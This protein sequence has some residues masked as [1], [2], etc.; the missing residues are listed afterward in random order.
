MRKALGLVFVAI[1]A[2][3]VSAQNP[4]GAIKGRVTD[5]SGAGVANAMVMATNQDTNAQVQ[6]TTDA[7]GRFS[8]ATL[9]P[10]AYTVDAAA[11]GLDGEADNVPVND[12]EVTSLKIEM[13]AAEGDDA[14]Q[15]NPAAGQAPPPEQAPATSDAAN[16]SAPPGMIDLGIAPL[17]PDEMNAVMTWIAAQVSAIELPYCYR[18][19]YGNG[20]GEPYTCNAGYERNGLLCYPKCK[21]GF[22]GNGPVCWQACPADF[23]DDGAYCGKPGSYGRGAGYVIWQGDQCNKDNPQGCEQ[24][25]AMWYPKCK[26]NFHAAGCCVCSPDCPPGMNDIGVSCQKPSYGRGA[27]EPLVAGLC[28][29][30]LQKD[31]AGALCYPTCKDD[32]HMVGPVCWQNCPSQQPFECG[33][34]CSTN[35]EK[36]AVGT[37]NMVL[38]P[39]ELA[40][41]LIPY[42]GEIAGAAHGVTEGVETGLK[43]GEQAATVGERIAASAAKLKTAY[44]TIKDAVKGGITQAV[45]GEENLEKITMVAKVGGRIY[46]AGSDVN[47]QIDLYSREYA[48]NFDKLTSP[49]IAAQIDQRFGK[50]GAYQVKREWGVR[51]I[52]LMLNADGFVTS[53]NQV[54]LASAIDVT[55]VSSVVAA[56]MKPICANNT[57]FPAVHPLY[58]N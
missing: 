22:A 11:P 13:G 40:A 34:G 49:E 53:T 19:S 41:S 3:V 58:S 21:D 39:I 43:V 17:S 54:N 10:G 46:V 56:F 29:P 33:V 32:F 25:G 31:P 2:S 30:G 47:K 6:L 52:F 14:G 8:F 18:Q 28:A 50:T 9:A 24:S 5:S 23:R 48:D 7:G 51:H 37:L 20:A 12:G 26:P 36:C 45:G 27:G 42:A 55:G 4:S 15:A 44:G 35:Q 1:L 16:Q 57:A 38:T